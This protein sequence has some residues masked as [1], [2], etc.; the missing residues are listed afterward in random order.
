LSIFRIDISAVG[1]LTIRGTRNS[2][3]IIECELASGGLGPIGRNRVGGRLITTA[4]RVR[5]PI[6]LTHDG[7]RLRSRRVAGVDARR[8]LKGVIA[9]ATTTTNKWRRV[10]RTALTK[11]SPSRI[12]N[13]NSLV[14]GRRVTLAAVAS[15]GVGAR[16][17]G[18]NFDWLLVANGELGHVSSRSIYEDC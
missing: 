12:E 7:G 18:L 4:V 13:E 5:A 17:R 14:V 11:D 16:G 9:K 3:L 8:G 15:D 6:L 2:L 1:A 10:A